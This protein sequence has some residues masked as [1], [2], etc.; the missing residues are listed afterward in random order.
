MPG[1]Y[2]VVLQYGSQK[3]HAPVT[4]QLDPRIHPPAGALEA[5]LALEMQLH[6]AIDRLDRAIAACPERARAQLGATRAGG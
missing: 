5:R 6:N 1:S 4:V 3:L 2:T